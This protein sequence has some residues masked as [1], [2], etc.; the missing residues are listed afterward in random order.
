MPNKKSHNTNTNV[1]IWPAVITA[2]AGI[3][4]AF[5]SY[6]AGIATIQIPLSATQ[7]A[8]SKQPSLILTSPVTPIE[9]QRT[10]V[11]IAIDSTKDWLNTELMVEKGD[12]ISIQVVG[13]RWATSRFLLSPAEKEGLPDAIKEQQIFR[14]P[15]YEQ[16]G[17]GLPESCQYYTVQNCPVPG[18]PWGALV[19][20][21][22]YD[23]PFFAGSKNV[24]VSPMNGYIFL[25]INDDPNY[26]EENFGVLAV[27]IDVL[28]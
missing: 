21:I 16:N 10:S 25:G 28:K 2:L 9:N 17:Q 6:R 23:S 27:V 20:R 13:G 3:I 8:E 22:N 7:T 14:Y 18:S 19:V 1:V 24:F 12:T 4:A 26:L 15:Q 5:L 11:P